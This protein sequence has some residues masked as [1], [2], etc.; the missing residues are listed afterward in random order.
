MVVFFS[1]LYYN[2][3]S[4]V[5]VKVKKIMLIF[6]IVIIFFINN[7]NILGLEDNYYQAPVDITTLNIYEI[8]DAIDKKYIT[9]E[10]LINLYLDRIKNYDKLYNSVISINEN[11]I[12]EAKILDL[13]YK[14]KGRRSLLHG[15]PV[16]LKDNIDFVSLPTTG[17]SFALKDSY[18]N[19]NAELVQ[20]LLDAGAIIIG[21]NNMSEFAFSVHNSY[22]SYGHVANAYNN[23]YTSYGSSG[24]TAVAVAASFAQV[25]IGTDTNSSIRTPASANNVIGIRPTYGI[26]SNDGIIPFDKD[27]ETA[28]IITKNVEDN[29]IVL[30]II[31]NYGNKYE[32]NKN[33]LSNIKIG[34]LTQLFQ[35]SGTSSVEILGPTYKPIVK[36]MENT[37]KI[38]EDL[39]ATII[40]ID[41]FYN[42]YYDNLRINT[43][44]GALFCYDFNQYIKNTNSVIKNYND[45]LANGGYVQN[46]RDY[47]ISCNSD[48]RLTNT[49]KTKDILKEEYR[50]YVEKVMTDFEVDILIYPTT[51]T[52][53][54]LLK[55]TQTK[56]VVSNS[57]VIAPTTGYPAINVP[58]G[59]DENLPYGMEM[60]ALKNQD[61]LL[62][63][64][65]YVYEKAVN[66]YYL[67]SI[68][69]V[70]YTIS[71]NVHKLKEL[72]ENYQND[73][74]YKV[75]NEK[76]I[77]FFQ[78]YNDIDI[79]EKALELIDEYNNFVIID[80]Y[81]IKGDN[82]YYIYYLIGLIITL[83]LTIVSLKKLK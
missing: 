9:Y 75:I 57:R 8:Q 3:F 18:P 7:F 15:I 33:D 47:N 2:E 68:S 80:E 56:F 67:P 25:G 64:I 43:Y 14:E 31:N 36:M 50:N 72:Y 65:A 26:I 81:K 60:V 32:I 45:L 71:E 78:N 17:G 52:N 66:Y 5:V 48:L 35:E 61:N 40:N 51:K 28:G 49:F 76:T 11:A 54:F 46:L 39:G 58:I 16:M 29:M 74:N 82:D 4:K 6:F 41:E 38:F 44:G 12:E 34:V 19:E 62:Y 30:S 10:S 42:S 27:R 13:E 21:K 59:F 83:I 79:E 55:D 37:I 53:T 70:L 22:S 77:I 24:G 1:L 20:K 69:P 63:N 23:N 73:E